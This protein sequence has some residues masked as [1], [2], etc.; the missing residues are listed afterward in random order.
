MEVLA[1]V[2]SLLLLMYLAYRGFSVILVA[3]LMALLAVVL[4]GSTEVMGHYTEIYMRGLGNFIIRYFPIFLLGAIFGK[5]MDQSGAAASI[6]NGIIK[7]LGARHAI[8]AIVLS[9]AVLTYGGV[10]IFIV[11][12]GVYPMAKSL[13]QKADIPKRLVPGTIALGSFTFSMTALP[14]TIQIHNVIPMPYFKTD[15][16]AAPLFGLLSS[17]LIAS[18]GILYLNGRSKSARENQ[19][20]YGFPDQMESKQSELPNLFLS[21][22]PIFLLISLNFL[23]ANIIIPRWDLAYLQTEKFGFTTA[24]NVKGIWAIIAA[25][26]ITVSLMV[27]L[28][29]KQL[30]N[31]LSSINEGIGGTMLPLFNTASEVGYGTTIATLAGFEVIKMFVLTL[32]PEKPLLSVAVAVNFLAGIT[33]SAS[34]GLAIALET[35]GERFHQM[36]LD[37]DI[38]TELMHRVSSMASSGLDSL[39]HN[40]AVITLLMICGLSH[41]QS[42]KEIAVT[43]LLIPVSV[44]I[45]MILLISYF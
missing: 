23:F 34:G 16:F 22:V 5:L 18:L 2:I 35:L 41:R 37:H 36:A 19:E 42:Y 4:S 26:S 6:A 38:S 14:G 12:F 25:M 7:N 28:L 29:K 20:G 15:A 43:T 8:I 40:G 45:S 13:F 39:P 27:I 30:P 11:A 24:D 3:P 44:L 21:L 32:F 17:L 1:V 10:S 33:G 9:C 31:P